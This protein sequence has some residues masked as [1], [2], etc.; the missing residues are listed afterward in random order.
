MSGGHDLTTIAACPHTTI[1][2]TDQ[3]VFSLPPSPFPLPSLFLPS[4]PPS[5]SSSPLL[6]YPRPM[7]VAMYDYEALGEDGNL[8]FDEGD[9][10]EV[11]EDIA[12]LAQSFPSV[13]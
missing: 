3:A 8:E 5:L 2:L 4:L 13:T 1:L 6:S 10:I 7:A 11:G 9:I 12:I